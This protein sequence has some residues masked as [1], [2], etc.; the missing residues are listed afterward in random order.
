MA[1][2]FLFDLDHTVLMGFHTHRMAYSYAIKEVFGIDFDVPRIEQTAGLTDP[3]IMA[4][5]ALGRGVGKGEIRQR[6]PEL[7]E[8][9]CKFFIENVSVNEGEIMKG[10]RKFISRLLEKGGKTGIVTGNLEPIGWKKLDLL[11]IRQLFHYG[12]FSS[13]SPYRWEIVEFVLKKAGFEDKR[14][15]VWLFGD[16]QKDIEA[17]RKAKVNVCSVATGSFSYE[18]L[19]KEKPD[20]LLHSFLDEK[21]EYFFKQQ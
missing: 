15:D 11:G 4:Q 13:D 1:K 2:L 12:G 18:L 21:A 6:M 16:T 5:M 20:V 7:D 8:M 19:E 9:A 10:A 14:N 3:L 17:A